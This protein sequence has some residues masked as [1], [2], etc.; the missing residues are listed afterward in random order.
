MKVKQLKHLTNLEFISGLG[1]LGYVPQFEGPYRTVQHRTAPYRTI[2]HRTGPY[3]GLY[4]TVQ[5]CTGY[6]MVL[7]TGVHTPEYPGLKC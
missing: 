1:I 5:D 6:C 3:R 4:S 7:Q 2:Q